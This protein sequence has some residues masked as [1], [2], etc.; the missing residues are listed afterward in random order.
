MY[1]IRSYYDLVGELGG[2]DHVA[3]VAHV[4]VDGHYSH[5]L[6][7]LDDALELEFGLGIDAG[8]NLFLGL[9]K[10][11]K[12]LL[13]GVDLGGKLCLALVKLLFLLLDEGFL[14]LEILVEFLEGPLFP[15]E[16]RITSYNVC[17][18]KLLRFPMT[19]GLIFVLF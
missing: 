12:L 7:A 5:A 4:A 1:A 11:G 9:V 19:G 10:G 8:R 13:H 6:L 14:A 16:I 15:L 2:K 3:A 17:Y 18:T